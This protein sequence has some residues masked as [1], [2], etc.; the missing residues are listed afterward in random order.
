MEDYLV[1]QGH[2]MQQHRESQIVKNNLFTT[3]CYSLTV[4]VMCKT[5]VYTDCV[6]PTFLPKV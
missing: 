3:N 2:T 1:Q 6:F 5:N 4:E